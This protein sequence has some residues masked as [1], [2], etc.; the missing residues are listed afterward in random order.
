VPSYN[1]LETSWNK[2][3]VRFVFSGVDK[4]FVHTKM[5]TNCRKMDLAPLLLTYLT[6]IF[7]MIAMKFLPI[8]LWRNNLKKMAQESDSGGLVYL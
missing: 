7:K 5:S 8:G 6:D 3:N 1:T 2:Y 4:P